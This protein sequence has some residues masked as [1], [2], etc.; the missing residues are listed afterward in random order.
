M[1]I[2]VDDVKNFIFKGF[3]DLVY[4]VIEVRPYLATSNFSPPTSS[5]I[6]LNPTNITPMSFA[7]GYVS[8]PEGEDQATDVYTMYS[9]D[10]DLRVVGKDAFTVAQAIVNGLRDPQVLKA[11]RRKGLGYY[12]SS[13]VRDISIPVNNERIETRAVATISAYFT[14]GGNARDG[15]DGWIERVTIDPTYKINNSILE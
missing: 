12:S 2:L 11:L 9:T 3:S 4:E 7:P 6:T 10:I 5:Y 14:Q 1:A 13:Q 15:S 8:W